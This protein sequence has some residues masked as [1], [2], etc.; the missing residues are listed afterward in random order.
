MIPSAGD[1][2]GY[3]RSRCC[4]GI[5][6][7]LSLEVGV[8][9]SVHGSLTIR[10]AQFHIWLRDIRSEFA[11]ILCREA[12]IASSTDVDTF[13][14]YPSC[15]SSNFV[16]NCFIDLWGYRTC[17]FDPYLAIACARAVK[18]MDVLED[19]D[20]SPKRAVYGNV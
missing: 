14:Y 16:R 11:D 18:K 3:K 15:H 13:V 20:D 9:D 12:T 19:S 8:Q 2:D 10:V 4:C 5:A 6:P 7:K 1:G 17:Y